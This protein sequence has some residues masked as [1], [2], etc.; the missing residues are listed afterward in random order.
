[1]DDGTAAL[2][3]DT[4]RTER[5]ARAPQSCER[6]VIGKDDATEVSARVQPR[7][8]TPRARDVDDDRFRAVGVR[9][10]TF[11]RRSGVQTVAP[12]ARGEPR[13][14]P[15][16]PKRRPRPPTVATRARAFPAARGRSRR[17][18]RA[19][20][21]RLGQVP[22]RPQRAPG[23]H[24]AAPRGRGRAS[25]HV[26]IEAS[27]VSTVDDTP[28][29]LRGR[30]RA[31]PRVSRQVGLRSRRRAHRR[32]V[33]PLLARRPEAVRR[34]RGDREAVLRPAVMGDETN[35]RGWGVSVGLEVGIQGVEPSPEW[36]SRG[37]G[38]G[39]QREVA[40]SSQEG[41]SIF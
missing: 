7:R 8:K 30:L 37:R 34:L 17:R 13:H 15:K 33:V 41:E 12:R 36:S 27:L 5:G 19:L 23:D 6:A 3:H 25:G 18:R 26:E 35:R 32:V 29:G 22:G 39:V 1:M 9:D 10:E 28:H 21:R 24:P 31:D 11:A 2:T 16:T 20:L 38:G 40:H 14:I 4:P